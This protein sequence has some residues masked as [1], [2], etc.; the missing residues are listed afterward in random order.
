[1]LQGGWQQYLVAGD[2][3]VTMHHGDMVVIPANTWHEE[4]LKSPR[5]RY[6]LFHSAHKE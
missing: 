2:K 5:M 6:I 3:S 4:V 1:M